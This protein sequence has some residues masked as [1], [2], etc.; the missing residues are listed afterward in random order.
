[1]QFPLKA[2]ASNTIKFS[3]L[4]GNYG[5]DIDGLGQAVKQ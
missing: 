1:V 3:M 2:G 5:P 4:P